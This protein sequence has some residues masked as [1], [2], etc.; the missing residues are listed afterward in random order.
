MGQSYDL[1]LQ[2]KL[3]SKSLSFRTHSA[4]TAVANTTTINW[5]V[6]YEVHLQ[7]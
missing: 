4:D 3:M 2:N 6:S 7:R 1:K 5:T